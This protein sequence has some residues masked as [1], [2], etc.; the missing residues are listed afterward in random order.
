MEQ[1]LALRHSFKPNQPLE[2]DLAQLVRAGQSKPRSFSLYGSDER[3]VDPYYVST[4]DFKRENSNA[5]TYLKNLGYINIEPTLARNP[6]EKFS[7][8][9]K[10]PSGHALLQIV[11]KPYNMREYQSLVGALDRIR[12]GERDTTPELQGTRMYV[13]IPFDQLRSQE[14]VRHGLGVIREKLADSANHLYQLNAVPQL[15]GEFVF[16]PINPSP[17][18]GTFLPDSRVS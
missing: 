15:S 14:E 2:A 4:P 10:S 16:R 13:N 8:A 17:Y 3:L 5:D 11:M 6:N 9:I 7:R 12:L 1:V 18:G